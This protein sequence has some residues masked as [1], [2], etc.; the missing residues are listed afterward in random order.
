MNWKTKLVLL[1]A[2]LQKPISVEA[3]VDVTALRK[4][5]LML[6]SWVL[7]YSTKM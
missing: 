1:F 3:G 2:K 6:R 5:R 4:N 7:S